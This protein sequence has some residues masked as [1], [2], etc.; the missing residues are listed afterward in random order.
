MQKVCAMEGFHQSPDLEHFLASHGFQNNTIDDVMGRIYSAS[1]SDSVIARTVFQATTDDEGE[2]IHR[3]SGRKWGD[4]V[5]PVGTIAIIDPVVPKSDGLSDTS[6]ESIE[7]SPRIVVFIAHP[8]NGKQKKVDLFVDGIVPMEHSN[9]D[10]QLMHAALLQIMLSIQAAAKQK[11]LE[12][13]TPCS[14]TKHSSTSSRGGHVGDKLL[15]LVDD[16]VRVDV[17][18]TQSAREKGSPLTM[19]T[20][21]SPF[22]DPSPEAVATK[23]NDLYESHIPVSGVE[24]LTLESPVSALS[25][26]E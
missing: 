21:V 16:V 3:E 15:F 11:A 18:G 24:V 23:V 14:P 6:M 2:I 7:S 25:D 20:Y 12:L 10:K 22:I 5:V 13:G 26:E 9:Q 19:T 4:D 1:P 17:N 8:G